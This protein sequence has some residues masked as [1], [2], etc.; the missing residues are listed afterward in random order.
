[1]GF[2]VVEGTVREVWAPVD[3][4]NSAK[5]LYQGGIVS[6]SLGS[7]LP[8]GDG[9]VT[10]GAAAGAVDTTGKAVPMG[11]ILGFNNSADSQAYTSGLET[12]VSVGTQA[13]QKARAQRGV[14]G[15]YPKKD[16]RLFAK[17]AVIGPNTIL[18]GPLYNGAYGT[19]LPTYANTLASTDGLTVTTSAVTFTPI[20]YNTT[21]Y[22]RK[23]AN[24]GLQRVAYSTSTTSHT[25]YVGFQEDI[26]VG[27][28]FCPAAVKEFGTCAVQ[29]DANATYIEMSAVAYSTD[30]YLI[31]VLELNMK[32]SGKERVIF[33]FNADQFCAA[34]A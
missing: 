18:E 34:R 14:E 20:T 29:F 3:F 24:A 17:L 16:G 2:K 26:A 19:V 8:A 1:M 6:A 28:V 5:T 12:G 31:D 11:V 22:C 9:I 32:E 15:I 7:N 23:G 33:K 21:W 27:D 25:F 13:A 4:S 30:Y 10:L